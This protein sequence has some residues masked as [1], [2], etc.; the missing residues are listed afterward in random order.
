[1]ALQGVY[2]KKIQNFSNVSAQSYAKVSFVNAT[3]QIGT[4]SVIFLSA[5]KAKILDIK[6]YSFTP[7]VADDSQNFI[8]QAYEHLK[9]LPDFAG[10]IDC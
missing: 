2:T 9:T 4:T 3:K 6:E 7:S 10:F 5:D 1:M 8:K